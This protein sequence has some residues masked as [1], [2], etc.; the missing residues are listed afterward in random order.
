MVLTDLADFTHLVTRLKY[1]PS[2][3]QDPSLS[4][5]ERVRG[6][7]LADS[8]SVTTLSRMWQML[9]KGIPEAENSSRPAGAAEMVIIRLAHAAHLPSPEDA[10]RRLL[11][12][13]EGGDG[14]QP[15]AAP[16]GGNGGGASAAYRTAAVAQQSVD[17]SARITPAQPV[18]HLHSC[19]LYTSPSP[20]DKR[21]SRMPSSA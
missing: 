7:E 5:V 9:L 15:G 21:Q 8:V 12:L 2:A 13:S 10:A 20:R 18:A 11:A 17:V 3:A 19:L 1:I 6:A 16:R 4:E 14:S